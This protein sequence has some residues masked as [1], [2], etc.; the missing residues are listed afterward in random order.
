MIT[1]SKRAAN[2]MIILFIVFTLLFGFWT[3]SAVETG[4]EAKADLTL[5]R[6]FSSKRILLDDEIAITYRIQPKPIETSVVKRPDREIYIVMDTSGSMDYNLEGKN[7]GR[8]E[9]K[10]LE[11]ARDAAEKF[12][13]KLK[14]D[15]GV[16]VGL[17]T[18][19]NI[20]AHVQSLTTNKD[21]VKNKINGLNANGGT[22]IGDGMRLAYYR[23]MDNKSTKEKPIEKYLILLT[24]GE[25]TYHSIYNY[26]GQFYL[27]DGIAPR[28]AGG[29][30][31]ATD[32]DKNYCFYIAEHF[33]GPSDIKSY[34][35]AFTKGSNANILNQIAQKAGGEYKRA[36]TSDA[37]ENVYDEIYNDII[38]DFS[39]KNIRFE[40]KF[41]EGLTAVSVPE[42]FAVN[43]QTVTGN[44]NQINYKLNAQKNIYEADPVEFTIK[45][46]GTNAGSYLLDSAKLSYKDI[47]SNEKTIKF[48]GSTV[49][50]VALQA[51]IELERSLSQEEIFVNEPFSVN[52]RIIP[53]EFGIDPGLEP[54]EQ[55]IVKNVVFT[56][57]FPE[58][59]TLISANEGFSITERNVTENLGDIV[60]A[61]D[62]SDGKYKASP[63][64]FAI[65]LK[66]EEGRY[67]LGEDNTSK[68]RYYDFDKETKE[69]SFPELNPEI[70]R[71][72]KPKLE[73]LNVKKK[74]EVVDITVKIT[75]PKRTDYGEI[76]LPVVNE[77]GTPAKDKDKD[78]LLVT[79]INGK[80]EVYT[81]NIVFENL[82]IY[83]T[84]RV[85][86][87]SVSKFGD[88]GETDIITIFEGI[89]VN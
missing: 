41:P 2:I 34:M 61:Y 11:I 39:V 44:F 10:R 3:S 79:R 53:K 32:N 4:P 88:E 42:G 9:K 43:G 25:P 7:A 26:S 21:L 16:K 8:Y 1:I 18:Y 62:R 31:Y 15:N 71:Y 46:K 73:V 33:I 37:L 13:E 38:V 17:I 64:N 20:G 81:D 6:E 45:L 80:D 35:I 5:S 85:W 55:L 54:P 76:R 12:L 86:L 28:Y 40:E 74:G 47:D 69:K 51:N 70:V 48:A 30:S 49:E 27:Q 50:V 83:K 82:S 67:S 36:E 14:G 58:G 68:I 65:T 29:G 23:L 75:L 52:Y 56:E 89:N 87:W 77:D 66:G 72:G 60:Y 78:E 19:D 57:E 59:L 22:N 84:H 63:I 24:D